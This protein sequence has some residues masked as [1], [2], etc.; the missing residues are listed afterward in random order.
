MERFVKLKEDVSL[1]SLAN[2]VND[3][4]IIIL[5]ESK[6]TGTIQIKVIGRMS[7]KQI[8]DAFHPYTVQK[9]YNE[10]PYPISG[11]GFIGYSLLKLKRIF[12]L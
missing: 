6:T 10:F 1:S 5:R 4:R 9:V 3:E 12:A 2:D 7:I 8:R 11:D